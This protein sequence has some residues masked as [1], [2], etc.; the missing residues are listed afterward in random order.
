[1][2]STET[3]THRFAESEFNVTIVFDAIS[4]LFMC[5]R[6]QKINNS[7]SPCQTIVPDDTFNAQ[8]NM[9]YKSRVL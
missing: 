5:I 2:C 9:E 6:K 8:L 3:S 4:W 1:M 7:H